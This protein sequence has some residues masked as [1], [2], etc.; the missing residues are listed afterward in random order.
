MNA[1]NRRTA[2]EKTPKLI[3]NE[4]SNRYEFQLEN[5]TAFIQYKKTKSNIYLIHT[6]V[7][8]ELWGQGV[9]SAI[10]LAAL[11]DI[12]DKKLTLIPYCPF[13]ARYIKRHPEWQTLVKK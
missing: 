10:V 12:K 2:M 4:E 7:P 8:Q 3:D 1:L 9:G 6:E 13:V 11:R 5:S